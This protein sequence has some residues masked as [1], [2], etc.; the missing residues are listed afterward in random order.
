MGLPLPRRS[1]SHGQ[2]HNVGRMTVIARND[3]SQLVGISRAELCSPGI[4]DA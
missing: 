3:P 1:R 2:S 4:A